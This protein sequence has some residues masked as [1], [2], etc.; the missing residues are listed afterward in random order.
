VDPITH[1]ISGAVVARVAAPP[2]SRRIRIDPARL[3]TAARWTAAGTLAALFPDI[4]FVLAF[5]DPLLYLRYHRGIT[6]SLLMLPVWAVL[7]G[8]LFAAVTRE[9]QQWPAY[10][11]VAGLGIGIHILGD[12]IT[13]YGT[14]ILA[15]LARDTF[16]FGTTFIVDPPLTLILLAGLIAAR[17]WPPRA[18]ALI[19]L[20]GCV[21]YVGVQAQMRAEAIAVAQARAG[22]LGLPPSAASAYPQPVS[23]SNWKLVVA[24]EEGYETALVHLRRREPPPDP[25]PD[26]G[27]LEVLRA[28]YRPPDALRW[29]LVPDMIPGHDGL[30]EA[31]WQHPALAGYRDF[32]RYPVVH[33]VQRGFRQHCVWFRD[34]RFD[35]PGRP[36]PFRYGMCF[37]PADGTWVR[38]QLGVW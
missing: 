28:A 2:F 38:D 15:P 21:A 23:V 9:R 35:L 14:M 7:L 31:A 6:H 5:V 34:L 13:P 24:R 37:D 20:V 4:D 19:A 27:F 18:V 8:L 30:V 22:A 10:A 12:L 33:R 11:F 26:A 32:A 17:W 3:P 16:E 1:A 25:P 29:R 36:P